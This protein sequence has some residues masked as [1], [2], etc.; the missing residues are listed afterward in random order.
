MSADATL[1]GVGV[2]PGD[3][4]LL[5][6]KAVRRAARGRPGLRARDGGPGRD[7]RDRRSDAAGA[8]AGRAEATVRAHVAADRLRRLP[9]ALDDRGGVTARRAA[10]LG[11]RR[12]GGGRGAST[13]AHG[14]VA[15]ATIG[16]PNVY[17]TFGYLA[18][19]RPRAAPGGA[20]RDRARHH[21][22]AGPGGAQR[23]P[24]LR[25]TRTAHAAAGSP[26]AWRSSPTRWRGPG[27]V[28]AYKGWRRHPELLAE[29]RRQGRL[30]DAVLGRSLGLPGERIG[31][32]D[33]TERRPA[34]PVD[35]CS[36]RP[37]ASTEEESC[38]AATARCGSS[39][40]A[41][42]RRTCSP[43]AAA[44]VH[45]RGGHRDLGGQPGA[46][47]RARS[48][49]APARRS[50]TRRSCPSRA[51]CRST[52]APPSEGLHVARIHSGDPALWG[53]VQ[54]QLDLC[55]ALGLAVEIVPG[56]SAFTA[57]AAIVERELTSP[58][59][60]PVGHPHPPR[61]RQDAD[62]ARRAGPRRSPGT[63]P[64]WRCSC[65][66]PAPGS[67]RTSCSPAATREDTPA[68]VAYQATWPD[69]LVV[70]LHGRRRWRRPSS[71]TSCGSTPSCLVGPALAAERHP[72]APVPPRALPR[73]SAGPSRP[74]APSCAARPA[75]AP[76]TPHRATP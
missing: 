44:Q 47:R 11:R 66:P 42:V 52:S 50:S 5:T 6:V 45:R 29:L 23:H 72:L 75:P 37:A 1:T 8:D 53:A 61:G 13:R 18:Q 64:R 49:P 27:T 9:F 56:V 34:V 69:E 35:A 71:S 14:P 10:R 3:P 4:D 20:G 76:G 65:P 41:R 17:S 55:R 22:H 30:D 48:T 38:D 19:T 60:R 68:V 62:A 26:R 16:D 33:D 7:H 40:P 12:P 46:R 24:A 32:A 73:A 67:C 15:F 63:A 54:E 36:F 58:R 31:P 28:V 39:E 70:A 59:G 2:G 21:R 43:C 57:V 51:C 74:P 25:G